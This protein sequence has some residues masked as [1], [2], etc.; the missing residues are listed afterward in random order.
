MGTRRVVGAIGVVGCVAFAGCGVRTGLYDGEAPDDAATDTFVDSGFDTHLPDTRLPDTRVPDTFVVDTFV[1]PDTFLP[2]T[3]KPDTFVPDTRDSALPDVLEPVVTFEVVLGGYH[4]CARIGAGTLR[5]W[6]QGISGQLGRTLDSGD[7]WPVPVDVVGLAPALQ[8]AAGNGHTCAVL[9]D[10]SVSCWGDNGAAQLGIGPKDVDAHPKPLPVVGLVG[11]VAEVAGGANE[12]CA[13]LTSGSVYCWGGRGFD[14][15]PAHILDGAA[16]ISVGREHACALLTDGT[17]SCWGANESGQLGNGT[18]T[19]SATPKKVT[20]ISGATFLGSGGHHTCVVVGTDLRCW[21]KNANGQLGDGTTTDRFSPVAVKGLG[22]FT[23]V[24]LGYE[25][26]CAR[27]SDGNIICWGQNRYGQLGDGTTT[28]RDV[29]T[30]TGLVADTV[31]SGSSALHTCAVTSG[32]LRC[33][34]MNGYGQVGNGDL[35]HTDATKPTLV[36]W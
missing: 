31:V 18:T 21:G 23:L 22:T 20:G 29:P 36:K 24:S 5:C 25:H 9:D 13:R 33:W 35:S 30:A 28:D 7:S 8:V 26:S 34:G 10:H 11:S 1:E 19:D 16:R 14:P 15:K 27:R 17:V 32:V 12:T 6:G 2:D 4:T 3:F